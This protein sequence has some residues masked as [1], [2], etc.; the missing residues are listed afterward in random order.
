ME[1][2]G[3]H[4]QEALDLPAGARA[5]RRRRNAWREVRPAL[6]DPLRGLQADGVV[7]AVRDGLLISDRENHCPV[8]AQTNAFSGGIE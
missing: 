1:I 7:V 6:Q 8:R 5:K 4:A 3:Y 2:D